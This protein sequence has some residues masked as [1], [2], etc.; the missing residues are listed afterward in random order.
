MP[1][2]HPLKAIR[3]NTVLESGK[4][5]IVFWHDGMSDEQVVA[6]GGE[7]IQLPCGQCIG[8]RLEYSRQWAVRCALESK[9]WEH[10]Y[11]VTLTYDDANVPLRDHFKVDKDTGEVIDVKTVMTLLPDDLKAFLKRLRTNAKRQYGNDNIRF[12]A[13]GEYGPLNMRPHYHLIL[14]NCPLPDLVLEKYANG[15]AYYRSA[16]LEKTWKKWFILVTDFSFE[17]AA[18]V[19]RY[20]LKK[21]KGLDSNYYSEN[22]IEPEFTRCSRRP[23]IARKY[24]DV[25]KDFIYNYDQVIV[26]N[27]KGTPIRCKPPKYFDR[28]FDIN[29]GEMLRD[30]KGK[31]KETALNYSELQL[32]KT[33]LQEPEYLCVKENNKM[34]SIKSLERTL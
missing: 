23:G 18:Y 3:T 9:K 11:F 29:N 12:F 24:L 28:I 16:F 26:T 8:C 34:L 32:S 27:G 15:Y 21:H 10:N 4:N 19:A 14:F 20:M 25:N 1:C 22:G 17:T 31:R 2:Y 30:I 7:V 33:D 6:T 13:C 5:K